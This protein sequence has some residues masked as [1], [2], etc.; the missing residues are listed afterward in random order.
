M[1]EKDSVAF[2]VG[3]VSEKTDGFEFGRKK[4]KPQDEELFPLFLHG[5]LDRVKIRGLD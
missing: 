1:V 2:E 4:S 5:K 3:P